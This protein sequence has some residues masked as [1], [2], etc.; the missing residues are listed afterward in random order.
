MRQQCGC[1]GTL[2]S[3]SLEPPCFT[4]LVADNKLV[5]RS[6]QYFT[7]F[8]NEY[9]LEES[10]TKPRP[11]D[12][13]ASKGEREKNRLKPGRVKNRIWIVK[14]HLLPHLFRWQNPIGGCCC[15]GK[16]G[17]FL[18]CDR[19]CSSILLSNACAS[20]KGMSMLLTYCYRNLVTWHVWCGGNVKV[21]ANACSCSGVVSMELI[22]SGVVGFFQSFRCSVS[23]QHAGSY[24]VFSLSGWK[25]LQGL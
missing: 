16:S 10:I 23:Q 11:A 1:H 17:N 21:S 15:K 8:S 9:Q 19:A 6:L 5:Q 12:Q 22:I 2:T 13:R 20:K 7:G 14:S 18:L 24:F 4:V 3:C 25:L